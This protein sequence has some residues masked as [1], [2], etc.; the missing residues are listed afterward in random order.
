MEKCCTWDNGSVWLKDWPCKIYVGQWPMFHGLL[1]LPYIIVID[2]NYFYT[3]WNGADQGYSCPSRHCSSFDSISNRNSCKQTVETLIRCW[4]LI[5]VYTVG[6]VSH[7]LDARHL[8]A[9]VKITLDN[10]SLVTRKPVFR[11]FDKV[12]LK[13][14]SA[15]T[16]ASYRLEI[17]DIEI[18]GII[19]PRQWT[20]KALIKLRRC[21]GWSAPLLFAYG[22]NRFSRDEAHLKNMVVKYIDCCKM[23]PYLFFKTI[24]HTFCSKI[25]FPVNQ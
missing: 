6:P 14:A 15:A 24:F 4:R 23:H 21:K 12:R 11:G 8:W 1:I 10:L 20:T 9:K 13:P 7:L 18:R 17:S 16:E 22:K 25:L 19:L 2:I 5:L 3:L